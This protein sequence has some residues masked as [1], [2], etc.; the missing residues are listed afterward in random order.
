V[1]GIVAAMGFAAE[2]A[3][4]L[5]LCGETYRKGDKGGTNEMNAQH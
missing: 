3:H 5:F 1:L 2:V 4:C